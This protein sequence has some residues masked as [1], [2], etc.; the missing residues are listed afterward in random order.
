MGLYLSNEQLSIDPLTPPPFYLIFIH[1]RWLQMRKNTW[2][3]VKKSHKLH[4]KFL[5]GEQ[6]AIII[7]IDEIILQNRKHIYYFQFGR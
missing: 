6:L 5:Q 3:Y 2:Q 4:I 1:P 7:F